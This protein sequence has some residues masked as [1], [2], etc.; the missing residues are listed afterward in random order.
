MIR[1]NKFVTRTLSIRISLMVV[2]AIA[3]LLMAALF[4]MFRYSRKAVK[5]EAIHKATQKLEATVQH[6]DN[7]LLSV[8]QAS[9]NIYFEVLPQLQQKEKMY[10][11]SRKLV[12]NNPYIVGC[13]IAFEP[14][15]YKEYGQY[16]M[17]YFHRA[18]SDVPN[19]S[20]DNIIQAETF[21]LKPYT[22]QTWYT[23]PIEKK[24]PCWI[25]PLKD[26]DT[27]GEAIIT[28]S[29]PI[30]NQERRAIGV[31]A[32]DV[33]LAVLSKVVLAAKPSPH[34][35]ATLLGS[36]GSYIVH[37]DSTILQHRTSEKDVMSGSDSSI[38][39]AALAMMAGE[40]GYKLIRQNG[41]NSYVFYKPFT[42]S[43]V[44]GRADQDLNWSVAIVYPEDDI[45]GEY[46]QLLHVVLLIAFVG[47]LLLLVLSQIITHRQLQPL[48][49]LTKMAKRIADG[50]YD[51]TVADTRQH[52][53]VGRLQAH[54][55]L[56]Q[57]ALANHM[58]EM[59]R[60]TKT[61]EERGE[62]LSKAYE[63][64]QEADRMKTAFLH[65]LTNQMIQPV[66]NIYDHVVRLHE[67]GK[68]M[69]QEEANQLVNDIL[70]QG[71]ITTDLLNEMLEAS[72]KEIKK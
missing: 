39:K 69:Q 19:A 61:L 1:L 63:Q 23:I 12:E 8:E 2:L 65:H 4:I 50:H 7:I 9:G 36:D 21:G 71:T 14:Y 55:V 27:E 32:V 57:Q 41:S 6:I 59:E 10:V 54:F 17:A 43:K 72:K 13:A 5:D 33:S 35:Y 56:M 46:N 24:H 40:T 22:E 18:V 51:E 64:A 30:F 52:D 44:P 31:L 60:L 42:L 11:Y 3:T 34:S 67:H 45:F 29:L 62:V 58:G 16:F 26:N 68:E 47:L 28:F 38:G 66:N 49:V 25:N 20:N 70:Q 37:P 15:Y 53:E 48:G